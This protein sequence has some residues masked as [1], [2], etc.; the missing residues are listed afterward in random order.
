[1]DTE[2]NIDEKFDSSFD[3][4]ASIPDATDAGSVKRPA[5][6]EQSDDAGVTKSKMIA[7]LVTKAYSL[8]AANLA[9]GFAEF[10]K[11]GEGGAK[12]AEANRSSISASAVKEDLDLAFADTDLSEDFRV[13]AT[14]IFEAAVQAK[15][16]AE[17]ARIDEETEANLN[18][19][20]EAKFAEINEQLNSYLDYVADSWLEENRLSV[21]NG[22]RADVMENFMTGLKG[23]FVEH[24]IEIPEDKVDVVEALTSRVDELTEKLNESQ[25][26]LIDQE[27][28]INAFAA[29]KVVSE[30]SE[31]LTDTQADKLKTL[32]ESVEFDSED[33]FRTKLVAIAEGYIA[34]KEVSR[35]TDQL[36]EEMDLEVTKPSVSVDPLMASIARS[37]SKSVKN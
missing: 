21:E 35:A 4:D 24:Y 13:K 25:N 31:G 11:L 27:K 14:A 5:D 23:L 9:P 3:V 22:I 34:K 16:T 8:S 28:T 33:N 6:K 7:D 17:L 36:N 37:I 29:A 18:E 15:V 2:K 1:M 30:V 10:M 12:S 32:A 19:A 20:V 26:E